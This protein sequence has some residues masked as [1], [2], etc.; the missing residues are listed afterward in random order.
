M[1]QIP[2]GRFKTYVVEAHAGQAL[3]REVLLRDSH[4]G[5]ERFCVCHSLTHLPVPGEFVTW[6]QWGQRYA[7]TPSLAIKKAKIAVMEELVRRLTEANSMKRSLV[8]LQEC[9]EVLKASQEPVRDEVR[10]RM[11]TNGPFCKS[12]QEDAASALGQNLSWIGEKERQA[13]VDEESEESLRRLL[14]HFFGPFLAPAPAIPQ[15][16]DAL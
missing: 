7:E 9:S 4:G 15:A 2:T 16:S 12:V 10:R 1:S 14:D 6:K 11:K 3:V 5:S 8:A 13:Y